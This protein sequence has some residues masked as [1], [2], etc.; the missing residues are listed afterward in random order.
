MYDEGVAIVMPHF[1][2]RS[3]ADVA[4]RLSLE[5]LK[6]AIRQILYALRYLHRQ[7]QIHRDIK[8]RDILIR[9]EDPLEL[10]VADF[11][12]ASVA[13]PLTHCGTEGYMAPEI[14]RNRE[15]R[16]PVPY[17]KAV[18]TYA[19][20]VLLLYCIGVELPLGPMLNQKKFSD[21]H[22]GSS[23]QQVLACCED[24]QRWGA[25]LLAD[26]LLC[27]D[28]RLRLSV[29]ECLQYP[30]LNPWW[31]VPWGVIPKDIREAADLELETRPENNPIQATALAKVFGKYLGDHVACGT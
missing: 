12:L 28:P 6:L 9:S 18:D 27:Y 26:H 20:G 1:H 15:R 2:Y 7:R 25:I 11:G 29:E 19:L 24:I 4:P 17:M 13:N 23:I 31:Y 14:L 5:Q 21:K 10:V 3:L 8:P 30:W 16:N 22:Y